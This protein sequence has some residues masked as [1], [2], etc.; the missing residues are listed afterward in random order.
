MGGGRGTFGQGSGEGVEELWSLWDRMMLPSLQFVATLAKGG[1]LIEVLLPAAW[2]AD[3]QTYV[4][5]A[6]RKA[7]MM[8]RFIRGLKGDMVAGMI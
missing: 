5:N 7:K 4:T 6:P 1:K 3:E 8:S 2:N